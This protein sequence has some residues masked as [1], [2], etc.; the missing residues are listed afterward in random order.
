MSSLLVCGT[1]SDAGKSV[2]VAGLCRYLS[3]LG[4]KVAP[5]K[6]Q[7]MSLN[8]AVTAAGEE[9]GRAQAAQAFAAR[10]EPEAVMNPVLLKPSTDIRA[11]V[12]VMGHPLT[13]TDGV[14]YGDLT[15]RLLPV[16]LDAFE[17]LRSRF[18]VVV[19]EGAGSLAEFNLR[20]RDIVNLGFARATRTPVVVV[21]DIDRGGSFAGLYGSLALL[22]GADQALVCGFILN[23]FRGDPSLLDDGLTRFAALTGRSFY[24][25]LPWLR[26]LTI[27]AEDSLDLSAYRSQPSPV[28]GAALRVAIVRL[29]SMSNFTDFEPLALEPGVS[30]SFTDS[31]S[32]IREADL[33]ILPGSKSTVADLRVL[34]NA[35]LDVAI[36]ARAE[37]GGPILGVCGGYQMLGQKIIDHVE[38]GAGDVDGLALLPVIT[39]FEDDKVLARRA[40]MSPR[41]DA[42]CEGYEIHHGCPRRVSGEPMLVT[43]D[44]DEGCIHG[45][46]WGTSWHGVFESDDYRRAFLGW[47]AAVN[48]VEWTPGDVSFGEAREAQT[49]RLAALITDHADTKAL[50]RL[51]EQGAP[52]GLPLLSPAGV[53]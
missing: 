46:V 48:E 3:D 51:I 34:R 18:D 38:S 53:G 36:Q 10:I 22:N 30:V 41:L 14:S 27:D 33:V 45:N 25:V 20:E 7:N 52:K 43:S 9:I 2:I 23:K 50:M 35:G 49:D 19:C 29:R 8:S 32:D 42:D 15:D 5:F 31:V 11:Q 47:V 40:G 26:D 44:G 21:A 12:I 28:H 16:V 13:T 6:A 24:G 4:I 1:S 39:E 37:E 17:S